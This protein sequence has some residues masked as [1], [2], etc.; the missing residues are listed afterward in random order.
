MTGPAHDQ[1]HVFLVAL[2]PRVEALM[3]EP[4]TGALEQAREEI[5]SLL[6]AYSDHF[7]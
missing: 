3:K 4:D 7:E 1:L 2:F 6:K 5:G